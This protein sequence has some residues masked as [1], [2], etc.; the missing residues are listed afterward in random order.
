MIVLLKE[1]HRSFFVRNIVIILR[2]LYTE[3]YGF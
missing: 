2:K 3:V 1:I